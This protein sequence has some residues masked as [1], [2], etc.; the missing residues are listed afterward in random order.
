MAWIRFAALLGAFV[1]SCG[2]LG[3]LAGACSRRRSWPH[4]ADIA[5]CTAIAFIWPALL[6]G[7]V[8]HDASNYQR[9][10]ENDPGDAPGMVMAGAIFVGAPILFVLGLPLALG[11][12]SMARRKKPD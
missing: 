7:G 3:Y 11:G 10:D 4:G 6:L 1:V 5:L 2:G 12:A 8:Y 9:R